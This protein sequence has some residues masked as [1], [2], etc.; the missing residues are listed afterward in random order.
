MAGPGPHTLNVLWPVCGPQNGSGR[1]GRLCPLVGPDGPGP[2]A[3]PGPGPATGRARPGGRARSGA[4]RPRRTR[5]ERRGAAGF[6]PTEG[7]G[8]PERGPPGRYGTP[9]GQPAAAGA[10]RAGHTEG[11]RRPVGGRPFPPRLRRG[12][13]RTQSVRRGAYPPRRQWR[14]V[15]AKAAGGY[16]PEML[17]KPVRLLT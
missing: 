11:H 15:A 17:E 16:P 13:R 12:G 3:G 1:V 5:N 7:G 8:V 14:G 9:P 2:N 6:A 10:A 4:L